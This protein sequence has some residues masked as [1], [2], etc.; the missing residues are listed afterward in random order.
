MNLL[1]APVAPG[2]APAVSGL[3]SAEAVE[4]ELRPARLP[5]RSLALFLDCLVMI[6]PGFLAVALVRSVAEHTDVALA[7]AALTVGLVLVFVGY[8]VLCETFLDGRSPGKRAMGL[9]VIREDGGPLRA[10]HALTRALV[11]LA[12][13]FPGMLLV[14]VCWPAGIITMLASRQGRRL[15]DLAAGTLVVHERDA[16][17]WRAAPAMPPLLAAWAATLDL[18]AVD[19]TLAL[20]IRQFVTRVRELREPYR[21]H[22]LRELAGEVTSRIVPPPPSAISPWLLLIAVLAERRRRQEAQLVVGRRMTYRVLPTFGHH[23][24]RF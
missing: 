8:P 6:V 14:F 15:G 3:V 24:S 2:D 19:D 9:R 18:T 23:A 5:S 7:Q 4:I 17:P 20:E 11:G 22:L 21:A 16:A 13:E 1:P 10:R 12:V